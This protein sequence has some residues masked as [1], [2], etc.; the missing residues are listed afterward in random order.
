MLQLPQNKLQC[1]TKLNSNKIYKII[2][3]KK[4]FCFLIILQKFSMSM[5]DIAHNQIIKTMC[6]ALCKRKCSRN[7]QQQHLQ[8]VEKKYNKYQSDN[9]LQ[10]RLHKQ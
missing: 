2:I 7:K 8:V 1:I 6:I 9:A 10:T 3:K 5:S 4:C